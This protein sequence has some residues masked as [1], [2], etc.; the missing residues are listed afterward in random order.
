MIA[1]DSIPRSILWL[2]LPISGLPILFSLSVSSTLPILA[3]YFSYLPD[4]VFKLKLFVCSPGITTL[5]VAPV[6][7]MIMDRFGRKPLLLF[8][9][10]LYWL[11]G[12]L[13]PFFF[14]SYYVLLAGRLCAG[15]AIGIIF[16]AANTLIADYFPMSERP[17]IISYQSIAIGLTAVIALLTSSLLINISW[18]FPFLLLWISVII[19]YYTYRYLPEKYTA[20][21]LYAHNNKPLTRICLLKIGWIYSL[22]IIHFICFFFLSTELPFQLHALGLQGL[23]IGASL[24]VINVATALGAIICLKLQNSVDTRRLFI[25]AYFFLAIGFVKIAHFTTWPAM[26]LWLSITGLG[27]GMLMNNA[28]SWL[29]RVTPLQ[30]RAKIMGF[31]FSCVYLGQFLSPFVVQLLNESIEATFSLIAYVLLLIGSLFLLPSLYKRWV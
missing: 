18:H 25:L 19:A 9:L 23:S 8:G 3:Q 22:T 6:A 4:S 14:N 31:Y 11:A 29:Q 5:L 24:S 20:Q 30:S 13:V 1:K 12:G 2:I 7:G 28:L 27:L 16:T 17:R 10:L 26:I 15:V 21:K